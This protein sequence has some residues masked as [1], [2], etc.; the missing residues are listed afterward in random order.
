MRPDIAP[1]G[2]IKR[3]R[4][5]TTVSYSQSH[6]D[7]Q[8]PI[9]KRRR[10]PGPLSLDAAT[11][12]PVFTQTTTSRLLSYPPLTPHTTGK[13]EAAL[14]S[15]FS[16]Q[17]EEEH[18]KFNIF[19]AL[20][21]HP[22]LTLYFTRFI[23]LQ[24]LVDLY[25]ISRPFHLIVSARFMAIVHGQTS[26]NA[27]LAPSCWPWKMYKG[28]CMRDP[29]RRLM[30]PKGGYGR[31]EVVRLADIEVASSERRSGAGHTT[32]LH[33]D[34]T[35][36]TKSSS[37]QK[38]KTVT[39]KDLRGIPTFRY[40]K[41]ATFRQQVV[42]DIVALFANEGIPLPDRIEETLAKI[43]LVLDIP[44]SMR[45]ISLIHNTEYWTNSDLIRA[46][47]FFLRLDLR[48]THPIYGSGS[49]VLRS[50]LLAQRSLSYLWKVLKREELRTPLDVLRMIVAFKYHPPRRYGP[51]VKS[52]LGMPLKRTGLLQYEFWGRRG[53]TKMMMGIE[54]LVL[55]EGIRRNM[56]LASNSVDFM[57][58]GFI[59]KS[60]SEDVWPQG[61]PDGDE[62]T[63]ELGVQ[64]ETSRNLFEVK[65][66]CF[67]NED[68]GDDG[69]TAWETDSDT[70]V[71][72]EKESSTT[73]ETLRDEDQDQCQKWWDST[74]DDQ[75]D[76]GD[77]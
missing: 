70:S 59:D 37:P 26:I 24:T 72:F 5:D 8:Q 14:G 32:Q 46:M 29:G 22:D 11:I 58:S 57:V 1:T 51:R 44:Y 75:T 41:M 18:P 16:R 12:P 6:M 66:G 62:E 77:G 76:V 49:T 4:D 17:S 36:P 39:V 67:E 28:L 15:S 53:R 73:G 42:E 43:W 61:K 40:L 25:S 33:Q 35:S 7:N 68:H 48:L 64:Q 50:M 56:E 30:E 55:R 2:L 71:D 13:L 10:L 65:A 60:T 63:E 74:S 3:S 19:P 52:I 27:P 20:L 45:R 34:R 54:A 9:L 47:T 31:N 21:Q 69:G 38:R 23:Q